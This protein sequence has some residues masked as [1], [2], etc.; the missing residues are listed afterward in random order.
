MNSKQE[1]ELQA[2]Q[3]IL[4]SD[5]ELELRQLEH[6]VDDIESRTRDVAEVLPNAVRRTPAAVL[7]QALGNPIASSLRRIARRERKMLAEVMFPVM[8]PAIR[9]AVVETLRS[10]VKT[11]NQVLDHSFSLRGIGW[12]IQALRSGVP[13]SEIVLKHTLLYR[14]EQVFLVHRT[15]G[16]LIAHQY[17]PDIVVRDSD[18][19]S[20][21]LTAIQDFM[22]D[23]FGGL[24]SNDLD[25][26]DTGDMTLWLIHDEDAFLACS[27]RGVPP[28]DLRDELRQLLDRILDTY[29]NRIRSFAGELEI[30][31]KDGLEALLEEA[32]DHMG[33]E[34]ET[35]SSTPWLLAIAG[36]ALVTWMSLLFFRSFNSDRE[37]LTHATQRLNAE[38]G[39]AIQSIQVDGPTLA[40][41]GLRDPMARPLSEVLPNEPT[42]SS[43]ESY[44]SLDESILLKRVRKWLAMPMSVSVALQN[45]VLVCRGTA[46][47]EWVAKQQKRADFLGYGLDLSGVSADDEMVQLRQA[48]A[49]PES[50]VLQRRDGRFHMLGSI[51]WRD[52][53]IVQSKVKAQGVSLHVE[54][55]LVAEVSRAQEL[56][57]QMSGELLS[58][59]AGDGLRSGAVADN[60]DQGFGELRRLTELMGGKLRVEV[61]PLNDGTGS[62]EENRRTRMERAALA[63]EKLIAQGVQS[64]EIEVIQQTPIELDGVR[65]FSLR[66]VDVS[67]RMVPAET[68]WE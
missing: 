14:V 59:G 43:F 22:Q 13:F 25:T 62:V 35:G 52:W 34:A 1:P 9:R 40:I 32:M 38:P 46:S 16:L 17:H 61:R 30:G 51:R 18:A 3:E 55:L 33:E 23:S 49:L 66:R 11:V 5:H 20:A 58:H 57:Q 56:C 15:S 8:M 27:I 68:E 31:D 37:R 50:V 53:N 45:H 10:W 39:Y 28:E 64:D 26:V 12:R 29:S 42:R 41:T 21:M 2:L 19:V 65:D 7:S 67:V 48:L 47:H 60:W 54:D 44:L 4:L 63:V 6:R 24:A 36:L